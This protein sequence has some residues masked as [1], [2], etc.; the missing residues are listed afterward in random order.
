MKTTEQPE[1]LRGVPP[2]QPQAEN[3]TSQDFIASLEVT[4]TVTPQDPLPTDGVSDPEHTKTGSDK[5]AVDDTFV[6]EAVDDIVAHESDELIEA[7][8]REA[9]ISSVPIATGPV[10]RFKQALSTWW[11]NKK[12]RN[13]TLFGIS[14]VV[15][16]LMTVPFSR[17]AILNA[18]GVRASATLHVVDAKSGQPIHGVDVLIAGNVGR[19]NDQ[20]QVTITDLPL[21]PTVLSLKK[22]SFAPVDQQTVIG[23][24]SNQYSDPIQLEPV[25]TQFAFT[26]TNWQSGTAI[27]KAEVTDGESVAVANDKGVAVLVVEPTEKDLEVTVRAQGYRSEKVV[28]LS[29]DTSAKKQALVP[30]NPDVF[31]SKRSGK[32]DL[33]KRDLDGKN[34]AVL[35]AENDNETGD[36]SLL[37]RQPGD[38]AAFVS[39]RDGKKNSDGYPLKNLY[40]VDVRAKS[41]SKVDGTESEDLILLGWSDNTVVFQ[42]IV[43]GASAGNPKRNRILAY[44]VETSKLIELTSANYFNDVK[45]IDGLVYGAANSG[46][47]PGGSAATQ[48]VRIAPDGSNRTVILNQEVWA[49]YRTDLQSL[50]ALA[51][52]NKWFAQTLGQQSMTA[53]AATSKTHREYVRSPANT[54]AAWVDQRDGKGVLLVQDIKG[55]SD[56]QVVSQGGLGWPIRWINDKQILVTVKSSQETATYIVDVPTKKIIKVGDITVTRNNGYNWY[57]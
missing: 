28:I 5:E 37:T 35:L 2:L 23:W 3:Q 34:E 7:K 52:N 56:V 17:Y 11:H 6:A 19:T 57:Y 50:Y 13:A 16:L 30:D 1:E 8:D 31:L 47:I 24:G 38:K 48:L 45:M 9:Q 53:T 41:V 43:E 29:T 20:G 10:E 4:S 18:C 21:G 22:R 40:I 27:E 42:K 32:L 15:C 44:N 51:P 12:A 55:G 33:Y 25:G 14:L 46:G 49:L 26:I 54:Q 39:T 36:V